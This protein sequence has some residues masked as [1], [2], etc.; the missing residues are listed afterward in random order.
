MAVSTAID[1]TK[2]SK[3][4]KQALIEEAKTATLTDADHDY[5]C[6]MMDFYGISEQEA[7]WRFYMSNFGEDALMVFET[8]EEML[9]T[10]GCNEIDAKYQN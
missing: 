6:G 10:A 9:A 5:I 4:Q 1:Y 7:M 2:L 3:Q 8:P